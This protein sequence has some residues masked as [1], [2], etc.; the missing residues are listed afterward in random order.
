MKFITE[1]L[2][3]IAVAFVSGAMLLWP[4]VSR[5]MAGATLGYHAATRMIN[6]QDAVVLDVRSNSEFSAG[7]L[8]QAR[9]IPVEDLD[10]RAGELPAGKP[11][12]IYC[13]TSA[14][15]GKAAATLRALGREPV[16]VLD[17][18]L[19]GWQQSGLPVVK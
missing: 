19:Q 10:K 3:L 14:R 8:P 18:G 4:L 7:H 6:D 15:A 12:I 16:Y 5:R 17:G 13:Q 1:N 9:N 11:V 2:F